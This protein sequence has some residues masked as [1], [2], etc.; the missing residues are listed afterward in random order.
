MSHSAKT[1]YSQFT[2]SAEPEI[3]SDSEIVPFSSDPE[4]NKKNLDDFLNM[5]VK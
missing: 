1:G 4:E 5:H 3:I 2:I